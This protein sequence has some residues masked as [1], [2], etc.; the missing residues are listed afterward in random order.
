MQVACQFLKVADGAGKLCC[1]SLHI[2]IIFESK[3]KKRFDFT[4]G[5]RESVLE[6]FQ[7]TARC[8]GNCR[9]GAFHCE[10]WT[11]RSIFC[12]S[13]IDRLHSKLPRTTGG[14]LNET[15]GIRDGFSCSV[16]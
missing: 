7:I 11:D 3:S 14:V 9:R 5:D 16:P 10:G 2:V 1:E 8:A 12:D 13:A 6:P 15:T 4:V